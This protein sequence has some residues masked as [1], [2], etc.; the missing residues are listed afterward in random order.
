MHYSAHPDDG[1]IAFVWAPRFDPD[2]VAENKY[3]ACDSGGFYWVSKVFSGGMNINRV[4]D[5]L[6]SANNIGL[7][8]RLVNG[9]GNGYYERQAYTAYMLRRLTDSIDVTQILI[10]SPAGKVTIHANMQP[11]E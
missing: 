3:N 5:R 9:G 10:I 1:G 2:I 6:Y 7:I 4:S 11:A 8:N